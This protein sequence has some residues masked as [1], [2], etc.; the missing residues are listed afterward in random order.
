MTLLLAVIE[1]DALKRLCEHPCQAC[2]SGLCIAPELSFVGTSRDCKATLLEEY[3]SQAE[4]WPI[5][6]ADELEYR[7]P[8]MPSAPSDNTGQGGAQRQAARPR[9]NTKQCPGALYNLEN[10][11]RQPN[12]LDP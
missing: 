3:R 1:R 10:P 9:P 2:V 5:G 11:E 12:A 4:K 7:Q 8:S 6:V